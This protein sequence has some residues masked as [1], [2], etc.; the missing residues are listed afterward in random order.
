MSAKSCILS[1][2]AGLLLSLA[3][4]AAE[5]RGIILKADTDKHQ[6][7]IEGR[8]LGVRGVVMTFQL[9]KDTQIQIGRKPA[10]PIDLVPGRRVRVA[11]ELQGDRRVALL[12]TLLG[13]PP[14][15]APPAPAAPNGEKSVSG[16]LRRISLTDREIVVIS[17][18]TQAGRDVETTV[19][20]PE[21][22]KIAKDQ[23]AISLDDLK[24]GDQ[25]LV[26]VDNRDGRLVARAI[27]LG[28]IT[29]PSSKPPQGQL[30]IQKI[31]STLKMLDLFLQLMDQKQ[32]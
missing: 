12:V 30:N 5:F 11:Y 10:Q 20:V 4:P 9:E 1:L 14:S 21:D 32:Q 28:A 8:G 18:G 2:F 19:F 7:T 15:A 16:V 13:G 27:Q 24:E 22:A 23:K 25:V 3:S 6:L 31:R 29:P 26:Q 17:P